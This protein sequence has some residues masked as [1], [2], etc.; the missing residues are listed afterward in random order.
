MDNGITVTDIIEGNY[1]KN[2]YSGN[3]E[4]I[5]KHVADP[6][7]VKS[8]DEMVKTDLDGAKK[9][10][11]NAINRNAIAG[12]AFQQYQSMAGEVEARNAEKRSEIPYAE[13]LYGKTL[14]S[15]ENVARRDQILES[16]KKAV[17]AMDV[18]SKKRGVS[19]AAEIKAQ[20]EILGENYDKA[21]QISDNFEDIA[22]KLGINKICGL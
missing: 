22:E 17:S 18:I 3:P 19:K 12:V 1:D 7:D 11:E 9:I 14:E 2:K 4:A 10:V 13:R 6:G 5:I 8:L 15:T 16:A 21:K 20:R